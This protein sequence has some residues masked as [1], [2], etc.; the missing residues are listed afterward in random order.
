MRRAG[1]S[2]RSSWPVRAWRAFAA[3]LA[4]DELL[5]ELPAP[6]Q[7]SDER[8]HDRARSRWRLHAQQLAIVA[9][10]SILIVCG[11][12]LSGRLVGSATGASTAQPQTNR[13]AVYPASSFSWSRPEQVDDSPPYAQPFAIDSLSCTS[14]TLCLAT[15][16]A[17]GQI[18]TSTAPTS[19]TPG[20][21]SVLN[22]SLISEDAT[23]YS[24]AG[25]SCV[26]AGAT[27]FCLADGRNFNNEAAV[28]GV[29]L[30]STDPT[31]GP[32]S[33]SQQGF[34]AHQFF[35]APLPRSSG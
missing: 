13:D 29:I 1:G 5:E 33:W 14:M 6:E 21:W 9:V 26:T 27:P 2:H 20:S 15:S 35:T 8:A 25:A 24:L 10:A 16:E 11:T 3:E 22:T 17:P 34:L 31:G 19:G 28:P 23:G 4:N 18:I 32:R 7:A 30:T 12:A